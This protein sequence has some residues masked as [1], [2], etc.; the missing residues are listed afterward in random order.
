[1][2]IN[3]TIFNNLVH[4]IIAMSLHAKILPWHINWDMT[5]SVKMGNLVWYQECQS[6]S[7]HSIYKIHSRTVNQ[8]TY[9]DIGDIAKYKCSHSIVIFTVIIACITTI[10]T[11][12]F[13][14]PYIVTVI[15]LK[16]VAENNISNID[17]IASTSDSYTW[18]H[19]ARW[20]TTTY[21]VQHKCWGAG[22]LSSAIVIGVSTLV[23]IFVPIIFWGIEV[24]DFDVA[25]RILP[26]SANNEV[27]TGASPWLKTSFKSLDRDDQSHYSWIDQLCVIGSSSATFA[28]DWY[29]DHRVGNTFIKTSRPRKFERFTESSAFTENASFIYVNKP[30]VWHQFTNKARPAAGPAIGVREAW[31]G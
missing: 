15:R 14:S 21:Q 6:H 12:S 11:I 28:A 26:L 16:T 7:T 8:T 4:A 1:M 3:E 5:Y 25:I 23:G 10:R 24:L 17:T 31:V 30:I 19:R 29:S 13:F 27:S 20:T 2:A 18:L 22:G 9:S